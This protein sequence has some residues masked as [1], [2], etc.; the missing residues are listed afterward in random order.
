MT[1]QL[2]E[3]EKQHD[4]P[5]RGGDRR[6]RRLWLWGAAAA[7]VLAMGV[8]AVLLLTTPS[9]SEVAQEAQ[10]EQGNVASTEPLSVEKPESAPIS[11]DEAVEV[12]RA[13]E[14][15]TAVVAALD[16]IL[17]RGDGSAVG[18]D[19]IA[20]DF[21]LGELQA[22]AQ[23]QMDNGYHQVGEAV[24]TSVTATDIN[25][26]GEPPTMTL[27]VCV[28]VSGIDI[29]DAAGNSQ[30]ASLY[31]PGHPVPHIYGAQFL[32]ETWKLASHSI[33]DD[34]TGVCGE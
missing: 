20:A 23:E 30:R 33:P 15:A 26:A 7:V 31:N 13:Q 29:L 10:G 3:M 28:D 11:D 17:T 14:S 5:R 32:D 25:L 4:D 21:V 19:A 18:A 12:A 6:R 8:T 1:N 24:V 34:V 27:L 9:G 2:S 16:E 22:R